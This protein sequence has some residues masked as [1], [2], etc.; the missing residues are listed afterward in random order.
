M[1]WGTGISGPLENHQSEQI[2]TA[3][4][5][6]NKRNRKGKES[7]MVKMA[8]TLQDGMDNCERKRNCQ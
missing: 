5:N 4:T 1:S 8:T 3:R 6:W 2:F 7:Q